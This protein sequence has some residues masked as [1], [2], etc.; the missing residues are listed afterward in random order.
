MGAERIVVVGAEG[1]DPVVAFELG[2]S[3]PTS[4]LHKK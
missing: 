3:F 1:A 4:G 2:L